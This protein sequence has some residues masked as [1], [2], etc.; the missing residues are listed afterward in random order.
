MIATRTGDFEI[1][2]MSTSTL[3]ARKG[4]QTR[5]LDETI[6]V[7]EEIQ[8]T[9]LLYF[10]TTTALLIGSLTKYRVNDREDYGS[11]GTHGS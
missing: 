7:G 4:K 8:G 6:E 5:D 2:G 9:E 1:L 10:L 3:C 11:S